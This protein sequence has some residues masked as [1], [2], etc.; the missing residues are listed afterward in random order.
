MNELNENTMMDLALEA[1]LILVV[2]LV[3]WRVMAR[4]TRKNNQPKGS[5]YFDTKYKNKWKRK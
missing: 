2:G 3:L 1:V 4:Y 5:S